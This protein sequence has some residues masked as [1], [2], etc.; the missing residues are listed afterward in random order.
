MY[1]R[2]NPVA[3]RRSLRLS[4]LSAAIVLATCASTWLVPAYAMES[5]DD[6]VMSDT[7]GADGLA[8]NVQASNVSYGN[9]YWQDGGATSNSLSLPGATLTNNV[10]TSPVNLAAQLNAGSSGTTPSLS[11]NLNLSPILFQAPQVLICSAAT[12][13]ASSSSTLLGGV[14][15]QTNNVTTASLV[16]TNGF[17]NSQGSA[18]VKLL[19]NNGNIFFTSNGNQLVTSDI[20]ANI[21]ASGR[22][23]VDATDGFRFSTSDKNGTQNGGVMLTAPGSWT[24][25]GTPINAGLQ[26]SLVM[27][28]G[29]TNSLSSSPNGV[30][31]FGATGSLPTLDLTVRGAT[32]T[33][34]TTDNVGGTVSGTP[35]S[36]I[37]GNAGGGNAI[38]AN[39]SATIQTGTGSNAFMLYVG[40]AGAGG[41]GIQMSN[42][43]PFSNVTATTINPAITTGNV[44]MNLLTASTTGLVM[45]IPTAL[46]GSTT[47]AANYFGLSALDTQ[48]ITGANSLFFA[49]RGLSIQGVPLNTAFYQNN[50]GVCTGTT[51]CTTGATP[52]SGFA[53]MP[54]FNG[55]NGNLTLSPTLNAS[56]QQSI[57]YSL[58][59]AMTGNNG[60]T[61]GT[62]T[63][64]SAT[65]GTLQE[66]AFFLADTSTTN[67]QY[68]GL[69]DINM[70]LKA[71]GVITFGGNSTSN[72]LNITIPNFRLALSAN[73]A[74]G[75]LPGAEPTT[76]GY[77]S[78]ISN[79]DTLFT[80]NLGLLGDPNNTNNAITI[81]TTSAK[82]SSLG[83]TADLTLAGTAGS[84]SV[85]T[86]LCASGNITAGVPN[87]TGTGTNGSSNF[88][89][90]VDNSGS[91]L[92]LDNITGRIQLG[93][94][95]QLVVGPMLNSSGYN[96]YNLTSTTPTPVNS[97]TI[98]SYVNINPQD[99]PG[100]ELLATLDFYP[101]T[102]GGA[103]TPIGKMVLTGGTI[104]SNLTLTP[105]TH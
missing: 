2:N 94:G 59:L 88:F 75:Y 47:T 67:P 33:S 60:G 55:V 81:T 102:S 69:R 78:F 86:G 5:I 38:A 52:V 9:L 71:N 73:L 35:N 46:T 76:G 1:S 51:T 58:A 26:F 90:L 92:G 57:A 27:Q 15:I 56:S 31:A 40:A 66:S 61:E 64:G 21:T 91:A 62:G 48:T 4:Q 39:M 6:Q 20:Y 101:S 37:F 24:A 103:A 104:I 80:M 8:I 14:A 36:S 79:K 42:F 43:V 74:A 3:I 89:R 99:V 44:Y 68:V 41:Y 53:I 63:G 10:S 87:Q 93:A 54:V 105:V 77:S 16:T 32:A 85:A 83:I 82:P 72:T 13:C 70:Y 65:A 98:T 23:W 95:S 100:N 45:P 29:T 28:N 49:V 12:T 7:T 34:M 11:L 84:C 25:A 96:P 17:L 19:L 97:A 22:I 18:V 30:I 50:V